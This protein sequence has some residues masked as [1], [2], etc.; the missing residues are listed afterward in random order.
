M[1][2]NLDWQPE[3]QQNKYNTGKTGVQ[4]HFP[5]RV[6]LFYIKIVVCC[7][8]M[9]KN[10]MYRSFLIW[11]ILKCVIWFGNHHL[12]VV[13][14]FVCTYEFESSVVWS[15][16]LL[17][18]TG[19]RAGARLRMVQKT[20]RTNKK[21]TWWPQGRWSPRLTSGARKSLER[22]PVNKVARHALEP[23]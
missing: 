18:G 8:I 4:L 20:R 17:V 9:C 11:T 16:M 23:G 3:Q 10:L 7:Y 5:L 15:F 21:D 13:E 1:H 2:V 6:L 19:L 22:G 14:R 12:I